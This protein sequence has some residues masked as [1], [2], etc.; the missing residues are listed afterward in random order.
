MVKLLAA[1]GNEL[2][3]EFWVLR[4]F[5]IFGHIEKKDWAERD[6]RFWPDVD[7]WCHFIKELRP[8]GESPSR[9]ENLNVGLLAVVIGQGTNLGISAISNSL[10]GISADMLQ[11][12]RGEHRHYLAD[13]LFFA[14]HG[15][16]RTGAYE[17]TVNKRTCLSFLSNAVLVWNTVKLFEIVSQLR[18][19]GETVRDIYMARNSPLPFRHVIPNGTYGFPRA[20]N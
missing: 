7:S 16:C 8:V 6:G 3:V 9:L 13:W 17:E 5:E 15:V 18:T 19:R 12:D 2:D 10:E 4:Y 1:G 14:D 11:L 20:G